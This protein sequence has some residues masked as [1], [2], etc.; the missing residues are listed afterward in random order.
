MISPEAVQVGLRGALN[1]MK[2][3]C[4]IDGEVEPQ[5]GI[6]VLNGQLSRTEILATRGGIVAKL[7]DVGDPISRDQVIVT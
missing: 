1:I 5:E 4:M 3:L 6:G 7:V 2:S